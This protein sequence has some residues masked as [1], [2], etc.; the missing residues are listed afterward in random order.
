M[1]TRFNP[2]HPGLFDA[3]LTR[4]DSLSL[5]SCS[6]LE[7]YTKQFNN[8][9][10]DIQ[11]FSTNFLEVW[12]IHRSHKGLGAAPKFDAYRTRYLDTHETFD[13][14][15]Q[16]KQVLGEAIIKCLNTFATDTLKNQAALVAAQPSRQGFTPSP[17][18]RTITEVVKFCNYCEQSYHTR[19]ECIILHPELRRKNKVGKSRGRNRG[20]NKP[21][22]QPRYLRTSI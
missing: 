9:L 5:S 8:A 11:D 12:L 10:R 18:T 17:H 2:N 21:H 19:E 15:M 6:S 4:L 22:D 3:K 1:E 7:D 14:A 20:R 13:N 16:P